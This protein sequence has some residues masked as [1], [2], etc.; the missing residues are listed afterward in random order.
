MIRSLE[1]GV[2][3]SL[4]DCNRIWLDDEPVPNRGPRSFRTA[5]YLACPLNDP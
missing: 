3:P 4:I 2:I 1:S 5:G